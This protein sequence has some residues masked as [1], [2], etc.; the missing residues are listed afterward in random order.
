MLELVFVLIGIALAVFFTVRLFVSLG[1]G[2]AKLRSKIWN[3]VRNVYD[4]LSGIG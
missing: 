1:D 4:S 2:R 3:W